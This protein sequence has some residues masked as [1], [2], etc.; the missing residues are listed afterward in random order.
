[1]LKWCRLVIIE[2]LHCDAHCIHHPQVKHLYLKLD[3]TVILCSLY[4]IYVLLGK[5]I[6]NIKLNIALRLMAHII[7]TSMKFLNVCFIFQTIVFLF[8]PSL[9][10][11]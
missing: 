9:E 11:M 5:Y 1:M 3:I 8:L 7:V 6:H 2:K 4:I 10:C